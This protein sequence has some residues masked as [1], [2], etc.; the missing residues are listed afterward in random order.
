[1]GEVAT[2][3]LSA[4]SMAPGTVAQLAE[5]ACVG[6]DAARYTASRLVS[7]GALVAVAG[8]RPAVLA[9]AQA[10]AADGTRVALERLR[11]FWE[12]SPEP[13]WRPVCQ[14]SPGED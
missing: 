1:M 8:G 11:S 9:G 12:C 5:R 13:G 4:A 14:P 7:A 3:L 6:Y 10:P 2:A